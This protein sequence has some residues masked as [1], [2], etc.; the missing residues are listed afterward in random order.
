MRIEVA[1]RSDAG[2]RRRTR[3]NEDALAAMLLG[4]GGA[5]VAVAAGIEGAPQGA[6]RPLTT[7]Y[8]CRKPGRDEV[9]AQSHA[10]LVVGVVVTGRGDA[11]TALSR[12]RRPSA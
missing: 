2:T 6:D 9:R 10:S 4:G 1:A 8:G 12:E 3:P 5:I 11:H 7:R